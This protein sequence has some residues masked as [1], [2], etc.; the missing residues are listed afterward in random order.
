MPK[1][2][3]A[4]N[5]IYSGVSCLILQAHTNA[6]IDAQQKMV[7]RN[8]KGMMAQNNQPIGNIIELP[9]ISPVISSFQSGFS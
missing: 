3:H 5:E 2:K 6:A 4:P 1:N 8:A 7:E 9:I